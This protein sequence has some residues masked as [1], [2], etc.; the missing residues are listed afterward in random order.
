MYWRKGAEEK[1]KYCAVLKRYEKFGFQLP[2]LNHFCE[3]EGCFC[4]DTGEMEYVCRNCEVNERYQT[5]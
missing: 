3:C 4:P 5:G 1:R 2:K